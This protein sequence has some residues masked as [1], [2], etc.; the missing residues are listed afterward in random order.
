[1]ELRK[2][3]LIR[4]TVFGEAGRAADRPITRAVAMAVIRNPFAG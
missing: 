2:T 1:M 4:E 3:S